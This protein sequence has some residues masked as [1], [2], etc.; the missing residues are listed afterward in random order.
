[1]NP[2]INWTNHETLK[3]MKILLNEISSSFNLSTICPCYAPRST[4]DATAALWPLLLGRE[5]NFL[6]NGSVLLKQK[7]YFIV[8]DEKP[9][10]P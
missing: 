4:Q 2:L 1:M 9:S 7:S 10:N 8:S 5:R 3:Q 6:G